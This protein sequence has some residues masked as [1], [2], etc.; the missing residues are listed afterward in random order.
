MAANQL[1]GD[2]ERASTH[3]TL[4]GLADDALARVEQENDALDQVHLNLGKVLLSAKTIDQQRRDTAR[5][6]EERIER[7][8]EAAELRRRLGGNLSTVDLH[9]PYEEADRSAGAATEAEVVD[10][11]LGESDQLLRDTD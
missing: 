3:P 7:E 9:D 4:A 11:L 1:A 6:L 10:R 5:K 8:R 2:A